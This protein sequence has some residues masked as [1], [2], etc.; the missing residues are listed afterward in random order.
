MEG[1]QGRCGFPL[2]SLR[3][4]RNLPSKRLVHKTSERT[5]ISFFPLLP[6]TDAILSPPSESHK[7]LSPFFHLLCSSRVWDEYL[8]VFQDSQVS[9]DRHRDDN[10][11]MVGPCVQ[12]LRSSAGS[13]AAAICHSALSNNSHAVQNFLPFL[14]QYVAQRDKP[15][16][17]SSLLCSC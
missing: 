10:F 8:S 1:L 13:K 3:A 16:R 4:P 9:P 17:F 14:S 6:P 12:L 15:E 7:L 2:R 5:L 11:F